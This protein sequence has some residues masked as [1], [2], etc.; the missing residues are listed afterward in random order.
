MKKRI[1]GIIIILFMMMTI[2]QMNLDKDLEI[3]IQL[4][5]FLSILIFYKWDDLIKMT[6]QKT[7]QGEKGKC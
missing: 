6:Q 4:G 3:T 1:L 7:K 5:F 2:W